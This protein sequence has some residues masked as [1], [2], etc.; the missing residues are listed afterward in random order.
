MIRADACE[1]AWA[2]PSRSGLRPVNWH[3]DPPASKRGMAARPPAPTSSAARIAVY[4]PGSRK[5]A[6]SAAILIT[7]NLKLGMPNLT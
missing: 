2:E 3:D 4:V 7:L 5:V 1:A 6:I